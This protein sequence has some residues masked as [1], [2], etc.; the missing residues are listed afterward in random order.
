MTI[1]EAASIVLEEERAPLHVHEIYERIL[2]HNLY[3]FKAKNPLH[4]L[5]GE[6]RR[7]CDNLSFPSAHKNKYFVRVVDGRYAL[8]AY[9]SDKN[10]R[11]TEGLLK[12]ESEHSVLEDKLEKSYK[13]YRDS[14]KN[15]LLEELKNLSPIEFERFAQC[16]L[17]AY[18]FL[19]VEVTAR[20]KDGGID[21]FG[22]LQAGLGVLN[23]AFQCKRWTKSAVGRREIDQFRGA[24]SGI[25]DQG[26]FFTTSAFTKEALGASSRPGAVPIVLIDGNNLVEIML[27][28]QVGVDIKILPKYTVALDE[29]LSYGDL[30]G[31][32]E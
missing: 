22:K 27:V 24:I 18:G 2:A 14:F 5:R 20:G 19:A 3:N 26:I 13:R 17:K 16:L 4:V 1:W 12:E 15:L 21:G 10:A 30:N 6:I 11:Q 28:R 31:E 32:P 9:T 8:P 29:M 25:Y 23:V 7:H